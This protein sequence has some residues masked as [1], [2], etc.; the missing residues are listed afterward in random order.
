MQALFQMF[1]NRNR[2]DLIPM[3]QAIQNKVGYLSPEAVSLVGDYLSISENKVYG[4]ATFY[5]SFRFSPRGYY[6]FKICNGTACHVCGVN[7]LL[8]ELSKHLEI[9]PGQATKDGFFSLEVVS[10]MGGCAQSPVLEVNG[11]Y[12]G[13]LTKDKLLELVRIFRDKGIDESR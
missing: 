1:P 7:S 11:E 8:G 5:D 2:D 6:H 3:L 10:C 9:E 4:V 12:H 13:H